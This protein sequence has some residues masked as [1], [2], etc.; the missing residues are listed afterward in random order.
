MI[1]IDITDEI[2]PFCKF[3]ASA[4]PEW[5]RKAAKSLGYEILKAT[6]K[7][8]RSGHP[9]GEQ[10]EKRLP[11]KIRKK[12]GYGKAW[13]GKLVGSKR[14]EPSAIG[15]EYKDGILRIGWTSRSAEKIGSLLEKGGAKPVSRFIRR[16]FCAS[17]V[18]LKWATTQL[19][20]PG[21]PIYEPMMKELRPAMAPII[22]KKF[23]DYM[24]NGTNFAKANARQRHYKVR[25]G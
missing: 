14:E 2:S 19:N 11:L 15:Y 6:K 4:H 16:L 12:L 21:R 18:P 10:F 9:G 17:G 5:L 7:G 24:K 8:V 20:V 25:G 3:I 1:D 23:N 22:E 13:Y